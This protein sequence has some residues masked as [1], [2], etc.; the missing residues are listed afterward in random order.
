MAQHL[1]TDRQV[2]AARPREKEYVLRDGSGLYLRV[3]PSGSRTW[4]Y[5]YTDLSGKAA[6]YALG[7]YPARTLANAREI[8]VKC[9]RSLLDGI[10]P[11]SKPQNVPKTVNQAV[12][13]WINESLKRRRND[14]GIYACRLRLK[15]DVLSQIGNN[16][17]RTVT[18]PQI[19]AL[20]DR[21]RTSGRPAQAGCILI[22]LVQMLNYAEDR[23][24][25]A[26]NPVRNLKKRDLDIVDVVRKRVLFPHELVLLRN[27]LTRHI[28]MTNAC[29]A[30]IWLS[31]STLARAGELARL[32]V[33]EIDWEK[34]TWFLHSHQTKSKR[35]HLIHLSEFAYHWLCQLRDSPFRRDDYLFPGTRGAVHAKNT[36]FSHQITQRQ[37]KDAQIEDAGTLVMPNG[38]WVMHDIRRTGATLM[39]EL[40]IPEEVI[41]KCL[42]HRTAESALVYTYQQQQR[43]HDRKAAF[44]LLSDYL[45]ALLGHPKDWHKVPQETNPEHVLLPSAHTQWT[46]ASHLPESDEKLLAAQVAQKLL[47]ELHQ[48]PSGIDRLQLQNRLNAFLTE[49]ASSH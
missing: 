12:A 42:N 8:A 33:Q 2:A 6:K 43:L 30:G 29:K 49:S 40:G 4:Y 5:R 37:K 19:I 28:R 3:M 18:R 36:S 46:T 16:L 41:E 23:H 35:E 20:L 44:D 24:W 27:A 34:R 21:V 10:D 17:L 26:M 15:K 11:R 47:A 48:S 7:S 1:L 45:I 25:I 9:K 14:R 31:L 38:A 39:G 22:D 32:R 13:Q